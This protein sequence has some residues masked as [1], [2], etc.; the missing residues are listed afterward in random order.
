MFSST[1]QPPLLSL[2]SSS[3][4]HPLSLFSVH[5]DPSHAPD[6]LVILISDQTSLPITP[7]DPGIDLIKP[8][9][10]DDQDVRDDSCAHTVL[11]IQS[12]VLTSTYIRCPP[13]PA[14]DTRT[15][16]AKSSLG[17]KLPW[18]HLQVRNLARDFSF[19]IG[20]ADAS[21]REGMIRCST[22][23]VR[24]LD[25]ITKAVYL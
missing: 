16:K 20:I 5:T 4:S 13:P 3:S 15:S 14:P 24:P 12:P 19:E 21:G 11:Q 6:S 1:T 18:I 7:S 25:P 23:Q 10:S 17:I 9:S 2:F 8:V 22:F